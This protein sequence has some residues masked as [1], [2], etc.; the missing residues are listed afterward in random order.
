MTFDLLERGGFAELLDWLRGAFAGWRYL[1]SSSYR[2]QI[3][4]GW[5]SDRW[6][7]IAWD[8]I[9]GAAGV[10]F[11]LF[12]LYAI[13]SLFVGFNWPSRLFYGPPSV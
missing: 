1:F 13:V 7:Y 5:R 10:A 11:S 4:A 12:I 6:Y 9:C 2:R 8:V 3:H